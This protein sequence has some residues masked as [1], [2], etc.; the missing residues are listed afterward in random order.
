MTNKDLISL[1]TTAWLQVFLISVN[2]LFLARGMWAG[3][4]VASWAISY[5]W[6]TNVRKVKDPSA[7]SRIVYATGAMM[8]ALSGILFVEL[9]S[10][11]I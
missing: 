9:I 10:L 5:T 7:I 6:V 3:V 11:I 4:A 2:T 8:G 1:A